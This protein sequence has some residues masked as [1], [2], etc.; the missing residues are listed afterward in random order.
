MKVVKMMKL[1]LPVFSLFASPAYGT[2]YYLTSSGRY[3]ADASKWKDADGN[4][5]GEAGTALSAEHDYVA[6][7]VGKALT[8]HGSCNSGSMTIGDVNGDGGTLAWVQSTIFPNRGLFLAK[9]SMYRSGSRMGVKSDVTVTASESVPFGL[10]GTKSTGSNSGFTFCNGGGS[11]RGEKG[12]GLSVGVKFDIATE[13]YSAAVDEGFLV[14][15]YNLADYKGQI[16]VTSKFDNASCNGGYGAAIQL[17]DS[18]GYFPGSL[19]VCS[20]GGLLL[21]AGADEFTVG[22]LELQS[23]AMVRTSIDLQNKKCVQLKPSQ[24]SVKGKVCVMAQYDQTATTDGEEVRC[25]FL[26]APAGM[27]LNAEDF[28]FRPD[29]TDENK[30]KTIPQRVRLEVSTED[31]VDILYLIVEPVVKLSVADNY[32]RNKGE[33]S[34]FEKAESWSDKSIPSGGR[35]YYIST[36]LQATS[37]DVDYVFPGKSF[38]HD[39][40][41][42]VIGGKRDV[43]ISNYVWKSGSIYTMQGANIVLKGKMSVRAVN[44][45]NFISW[46]S[47]PLDINADISGSG[48]LH[49]DNVDTDS[50]TG[51]FTLSGDN[52]EYKGKIYASN[53]YSGTVD[54]NGKRCVNLH[55]SNAGNLGGVLNTF[56]Y[57]ALSLSGYAR[58]IPTE[59]MTLPKMLNRGVFVNGNGVIAPG[60][61]ASLRIECPITMNGTLHKAGLGVLEMAGEIRFYDAENETSVETPRN[62]ADVLEL[63][64]GTLKIA[65]TN[66]CNGLC[67]TVYDGTSIL[68]PK[69]GTD[70]DLDKYGLYNVK[71]GAAPFVL[72]EGVSK[73]PIAFEEQLSADSLEGMVT[74]AL[75]T[76][77]NS[78]VESVRS[79]LPY[80]VKPYQGVRASIVEIPLADEEATTFACVTKRYG[81]VISIK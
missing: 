30:S 38:I 55:I 64:G 28:V 58:L 34:A 72:A 13:T 63:R 59:T 42:F 81:L 17:D 4:Q 75:F 48:D 8:A 76:V 45:C 24:L 41:R 1:A 62:E 66:A 77:A 21:A 14:I 39:S 46:A 11:L 25:A 56:T 78:A 61:G 20:G 44:E 70:A 23:G 69:P 37:D 60:E 19:R 50:A 2:V 68:L 40:G 79:M 53:S 27:R 54:I 74:N 57:N 5:S 67:I 12:T 7:G 22:G 15:F 47:F 33:S 18:K 49:F 73:L 29:Q 51:I 71:A 65:S 52:S 31:G 32:N 35:H 16:S 80:G 9:G 10:Y 26:S 6:R 3:C 43:V 36:D